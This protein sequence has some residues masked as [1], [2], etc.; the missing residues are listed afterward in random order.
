MVRDDYEALHRT[1]PPLE[2]HGPELWIERGRFLELFPAQ[3]RL[4]IRLA[5][6]KL[7]AEVE[8]SY[9]GTLSAVDLITEHIH[10]V[11]TRLDGDI[12]L[13][14]SDD[15]VILFAKMGYPAGC[16][17]M[18]AES[19]VQIE[20]AGR[21]K[22]PG[23]DNS[24]WLDVRRIESGGNPDPS[25]QLTI[26]LAIPDA[27]TIELRTRQAGDRFRFTTGQSQKLSDTLINM[28]IPAH[29][30]DRIPLLLVNGEIG[31]FIAPTAAG[32]KVRAAML[33]PNIG[34]AQ[35]WQ[36]TFVET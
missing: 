4:L 8:I 2:T 14:I 1:L 32:P 9:E 31:G 3:Q 28:K 16:P 30:R 24:W 13:R 36:F 15:K 29:W 21:Y 33:F 34:N 12:W 11:S 18:E 25:G 5:A 20:G 17:W 26:I 19:Y 22:L 23:A 6:Q 7:S 27:R 10:G 35:R